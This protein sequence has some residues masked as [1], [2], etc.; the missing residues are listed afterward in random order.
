MNIEFQIHWLSITIWK[1]MVEGLEIWNKY[2]EK[3]L[4]PMIPAGHGGKGFQLLYNSLLSSKLYARPIGQHGV[5]DPYFNIE[6]P[7]SACEA[8]PP[9]KFQEFVIEVKAMEKANFTRLDFAWDS[10]GFSPLDVKQAV[11]GQQFRSHLRRKTLFYGVEPLENKEDGTVGTTSLRV[12]SLSSERLIRVYDKRG[13]VRI[14]LMM[15]AKR[16][17]AV[18]RDVLIHPPEEWPENAIGHLRDYVDFQDDDGMLLTWW[19]KFV[20][21][22]SRSRMYVTDARQ[23]ELEKI[24]DWLMTKVSSTY[25]VA[26]DV[27]G[28]DLMLAMLKYGK[29]HRGKRFDALLELKNKQE[30]S[31]DEK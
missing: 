19:A 16:A 22:V 6:L 31:K 12:G 29:A 20:N 27:L 26:V 17:D 13:P 7:G 3:Y 9:E 28:P 14:E 24:T 15:R 18:A 25:S 4:G 21:S 8:I 23:K 10:V 1:G 2:F 30:A 5:A 11:E